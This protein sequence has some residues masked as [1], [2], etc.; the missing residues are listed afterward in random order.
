MWRLVSTM[1]LMGA[2]VFMA[3]ARAQAGSADFV[4]PQDEYG[5]D[6]VSLHAVEAGLGDESA[7]SVQLSVQTRCTDSMSVSH[8]HSVSARATEPV[9]YGK[10]DYR[11]TEVGSAHV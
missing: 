9:R 2:S 8:Q 1:V 3:V 4:Q 6:S 7:I 11:L 10:A 5:A